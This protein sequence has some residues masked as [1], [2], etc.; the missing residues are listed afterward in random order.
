[1]FWL[2]G[3][4]DEATVD[5]QYLSTGTEEKHQSHQ[6]VTEQRYGIPTLKTV[7]FI[8]TRVLHLKTRF[9][10]MTMWLRLTEWSANDEIKERQQKVAGVA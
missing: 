6:Q 4:R 9:T 1:M 2:D 7:L 3:R 5:I 8:N 10:G